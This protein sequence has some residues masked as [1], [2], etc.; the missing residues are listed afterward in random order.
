MQKNM[1]N[2]VLSLFC[3]AGGC[4]LGFEQAGYKVLFATD[5]DKAA[6]E[7]YTAN[8]KRTRFIKDDINNLNFSSILSACKV[9]PG[10]IDILIGGPP[11]QG[12]STAGLRFWEDPRN[13]LLKSYVNALKFIKPKW[14]LMENVEGL[15]TAKNGEYVHEAVKAF[16]SLGYAVRVEKVYAHEYGIP[17]RRKRVLIIG[18][19]IGID[20]KFPEP[21]ILLKGRIF[22]NSNVTLQH[23][24]GSLPGASNDQKAEIHYETE[25]SNQLEDY[26]RGSSQIITDHSYPKQSPMQRDRIRCLKSGQTMKDLPAHL[27]HESFNKRANRRVMDGTPTG[28][29]GG[30]PSGLKRLIYDEPCLTITGAA[31]REFIHPIYD[32]PLTIRECARIQT[33][34][35]DFKFSGSTSEKIQQIGNAIPPLIARIFAEHIRDGYGFIGQTTQK[36][37]FISYSVTKAEAMSPALK[38]TC[39]LL[40]GVLN[41]FSQGELWL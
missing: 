35:D 18:N 17:Q 23:T 28:K 38:K 10:E 22:R 40:D 12:F 5:F 16:V 7:T 25:V 4:S 26:L 41:N 2:T 21:T 30:S 1:S 37:R 39:M 14:F 33:F 9:S 27:Q 11:C 34:P 19:R 15:L 24:I 20:F 8:F 29:R 3:G 36:G 6:S 31:T 32:R 13:N